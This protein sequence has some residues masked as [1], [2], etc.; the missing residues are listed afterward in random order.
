V[1]WRL[2]LPP[3]AEEEIKIA[4]R[5]YESQRPLLGRR[6][7]NEIVRV[8][9][10]VESNPFLNSRRDAIRN[11]RWRIARPFPYRVIYEIDD[12]KRLI[13][14]LTILHTARDDQ[15]S[16]RPSLEDDR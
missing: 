6:F 13:I 3:Q 7:Q 16:H 2:I 14:V 9:R 12:Q 15:H 8:L 4:A 11:L 1:S 10:S 5:W